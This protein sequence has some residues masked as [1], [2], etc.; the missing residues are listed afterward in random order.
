MNARLTLLA[1]LAIAM[2]TVSSPALGA[3]AAGD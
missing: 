3:D 1:L 2:P